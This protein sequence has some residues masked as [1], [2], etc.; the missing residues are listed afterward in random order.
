[1][2]APTDAPFAPA[3]PAAKA[4]Q[5]LLFASLALAAVAVVSGLLQLGLLSRA[6]SGGITES[7][8]AANDSRQQLVALFQ[9]LLLVATGVAFLVWLHA[10]RK[11]LPALGGRE[12]KFTPGWAVGWFFV[13]FLNLVRPYQVMSEVWHA[14]DPSGLERDTASDG[15]AVRNRLA[16][17]A[18][19]VWWWGLFLLSNFSGR[20]GASMA[21][22][23]SPTLEQLRQ[24]S[25]VLVASDAMRVIAALVAIR[26]VIRISEWQTQRWDRVCQLGGERLTGSE[27]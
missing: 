18:L 22:S 24:A 20:L 12:F 11:N 15:P 4:T 10:A 27:P 8:A 26:L 5:A 9:L 13:P 19:V 14:S 21:G 17:P 16:A 6:A 3:E 7:E 2:T 23:A 1:M 25:I